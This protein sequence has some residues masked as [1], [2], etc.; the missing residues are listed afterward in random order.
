MLHISEDVIP[1]EGRR[2]RV[3]RTESR[4]PVASELVGIDRGP[5]SSAALMWGL[6]QQ[7]GPRSLQN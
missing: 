6:Q 5:T 1:A 3:R 7:L 2:P 4:K